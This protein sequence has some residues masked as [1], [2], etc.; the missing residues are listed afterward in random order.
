VPAW[1]AF[2]A[3]PLMRRDWALSR[4]LASG[5][6]AKAEPL[7]GGM[8]PIEAELYRRDWT[9][10]R[11]RVADEG[12]GAAR[13][14]SSRVEE[15]SMM[16]AAGAL[17]RGFYEPVGGKEDGSPEEARARDQTLRCKERESVCALA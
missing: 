8:L 9:A 15:R 14:A 7:E 4:I 1:A 16:W 13:R 6:M 12:V 5:D 11:A 17:L 3:L 2:F 10:G